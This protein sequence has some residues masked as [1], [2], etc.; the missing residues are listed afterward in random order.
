VKI[1]K[2]WPVYIPGFEAFTFYV[3]KFF[4][5]EGHWSVTEAYSGMGVANGNTRTAA[6]EH[7]LE[8]LQRNGFEKVRMVIHEAYKKYGYIYNQRLTEVNGVY[9]EIG[10]EDITSMNIEEFKKLTGREES[11]EDLIQ[12]FISNSI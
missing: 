6:I 8:T 3:H 1:H 10:V 9:D 11:P 5:K 7:A 12:S 2:A 4:N